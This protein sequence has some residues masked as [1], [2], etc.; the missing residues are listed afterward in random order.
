MKVYVIVRYDYMH[1]N[2]PQAEIVGVTD[3]EKNAYKAKDFMSA[4]D[5]REY[6]VFETEKL[7]APVR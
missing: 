2:S 1:T 7:D 5:H 6:T 4:T 3:T